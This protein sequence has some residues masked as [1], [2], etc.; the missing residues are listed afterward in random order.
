M[1]LQS[2]FLTS[3]V[4]TRLGLEAAYLA[5]NGLTGALDIFEFPLGWCNFTADI[6]IPSFI[7]DALGVVW[8][9]KSMSFKMVPGCAYVS[10]VA[11]CL[12]EIL[13]ANPS[14]DHREIAEIVVQA[15][16]LMSVMDDLARPFTSIDEL[17]RTL[18]HV[19]LNFYIP[20]NVAVMLI[21]KKLTPEQLSMSRILDPEIHE[22]AKKVK[23]MSSMGSTTDTLGLVSGLK[24]TAR[25][26]QVIASFDKAKADEL[27]MAFGVKVT[28]KVNDGTVLGAE[29]K[30]PSGSPKNRVPIKTKF[31]QEAR[32]IGMVDEEINAILERVRHLDTIENIRDDLI[33][34]LCH[35]LD[36]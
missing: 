4:P 29:V 23:T 18:S 11:D 31:T 8:V 36:S 14:L 30:S 13:I 35:P 10:P 20:Y 34:F 15:S 1:G 5:R 3:S 25:N 28:I 2:K 27:D 17:K 26:N 9:T 16:V 19:A 6:P 7:N 32:S 22:L 12:R 33:P 21:D 24:I